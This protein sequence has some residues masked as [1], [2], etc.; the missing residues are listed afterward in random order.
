MLLPLV[1]I[2]RSN[3]A[4][5][6]A[7]AIAASGDAAST[8]AAARPQLQEPLLNGS[9]AQRAAECAS[10]TAAVAAGRRPEL[11]HLASAPCYAD[12]C[13]VG[14]HERIQMLLVCP[15]EMNVAA[16]PTGLVIGTRVSLE[17]N[18]LLEQAANGYDAPLATTPK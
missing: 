1:W 7:R 3:A 9:T 10:E 5:A 13:P 4:K 17:R 14:P 6:Q 18:R 2:L 12:T 15:A 8:A 11:R 16:P